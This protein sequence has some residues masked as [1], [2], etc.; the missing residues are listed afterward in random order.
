MKTEK[1]IRP[2]KFAKEQNVTRQTIYNW[3]KSGKIKSKEIDGY[4][5][6][7]ILQ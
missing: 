5:F 3:I 4:I 1:Y 2:S 6:V 7:I